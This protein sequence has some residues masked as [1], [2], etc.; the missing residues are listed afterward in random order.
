MTRLE[1]LG[2]FAIACA[3]AAACFSVGYARGSSQ[4]RWVCEQRQDCMIRGIAERLGVIGEG[5]WE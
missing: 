2:S 3:F 1:W 4:A 5:C